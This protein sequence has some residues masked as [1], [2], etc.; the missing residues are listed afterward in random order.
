MCPVSQ[1]TRNPFLSFPYNEGT[2]ETHHLVPKAHRRW[3]VAKSGPGGAQAHPEPGQE[4]LRF[5]PEVTRAQSPSP[6]LPKQRDL[7]APEEPK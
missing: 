2:H 1:D 5:L 3:K 4:G 7:G 6:A